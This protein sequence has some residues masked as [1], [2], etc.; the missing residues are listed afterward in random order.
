MTSTD[1]NNDQDPTIQALFSAADE[2][3]DGHHFIGAV[4]AT[5]N[6]NPASHYLWGL[7]LAGCVALA[8]L[9]ML[10]IATNLT[11]VALLQ[12]VEIDNGLWADLLAPINNFGSTAAIVF[13]LIQTTQKRLLPALGRN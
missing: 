5:G 2:D 6:S 9:P 3:F 7:A 1:I 10:D 12:L 13:K 11:Q 8:I 4:A